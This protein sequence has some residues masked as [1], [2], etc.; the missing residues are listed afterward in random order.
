MAKS[1]EGKETPLM[2]QYNQIK[3]KNPDALLLFRVGDFYETFGKDAIIAA[4][5][6]GIVLTKRSNGAAND[7]ELAG[8]PY[9]ALDTYLPKLIR[10]GYRVA[11]CEQLEDPKTTKKIVKRGVTEMITPGV[12]M[13]DQILDHR[14]NNFLASVYL[15]K[16]MSGIAFLDIST[17]EFYVSEG[18]DDYLDNLLQSFQPSEVIFAKSKQ[19]DFKARFGTK[20]YTYFLDD[21]IFSEDFARD[22]LL[23]HFETP[24][25]KGYGVDEMKLSVSAAG[26]ALH[27]IKETSRT[28]LSHISRI[29]R[30]ERN[31]SMWLDRFTVRN[32]ELLYPT[33]DD[34]KS[35][36][37]IIDAT[38]SPMG[39]RLMKKWLMMPLL[40]LKQIS[41]R[42]L[43]VDTFV[44]EPDLSELLGKQLKQ[45]GDIERLISKVSTAKINPREVNQLRR[46]LTALKPIKDIL[47]Q[48][49][50]KVLKKMSDQI[51]LCD[52][53]RTKIEDELEEEVGVHINKGGLFKKGINENLDK[54]RELSTSGKG[55]LTALQ[56]REVEKTGISSLKIGFNNVFGYYLEVTHKHKDKVPEDWMRKQ[57]LVNAERYITPELKE[58]EEKILG[59]EEKIVVLEEELFKGLVS[60]MQD[61]INA[62]QINANV[63]ARLDCLLSFADTA[64][65]YNYCRPEVHKGYE[66]TIKEGRHPVIER[67]LSDDSPFVP[68]DL[69][70]DNENCQIMMIT[71]PNMSGK[72]AL[73]RQTALIT[74]MAQIG[75]YVPARKAL[76]PLTDKIFTR[77]GASDNISTGE[78]TFMVEMHETASILNNISSRSLILLDEIGRGTSTYDGL[79]IAWSI[80]EYIHSNEIA[81]P[82]TLFATHYHELNEL[83]EKLPRIKNFHVATKES[84]QKVIF[85]RKLK[86]GGSHHSFGIH[87]AKMAGMPPEIIKRSKEILSRLEDKAIAKDMKQ[88][89]KSIPDSYQLNIFQVDDPILE[90]IR[91]ELSNIDINSLTP[92]DA[93]MKLHELIKQMKEKEEEA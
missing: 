81:R 35:L 14:K 12:A 61:Y 59:A 47:E 93:L 84:G 64:S 58:Y 31:N 91:E 15:T 13:N 11:I 72:S 36:L 51:H 10:A 37:Q 48:S 7:M 38:I 1:N 44:K 63:M 19:K 57:T 25:L 87:V 66:L 73:L 54:L 45:I 43:V 6:L 49:E 17:G 2:K 79:S 16:D 85:L 5:V 65:K 52:L 3:S 26:A 83:A 18:P 23:T 40:D 24:N 68:N 80:A 30:L 9:H 32:L 92:M 70:L 28:A 67:Q 62:I 56:K 42:H 53:L 34:G 27:Y 69:D 82:K 86:P 50:N 89:I 71:G 90:K 39:A 29:S 20:H 75:S 46:A 78:S 55:Y 33:M 88:K 77:V 41:E 8:F 74:L 22:T 21:W 4:D 60:Y 76:I